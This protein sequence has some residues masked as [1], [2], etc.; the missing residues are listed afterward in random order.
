MRTQISKPK[1]VGTVSSVAADAVVGH[2]GADDD[3]QGSEDEEGD[4]ESDLLDGRLVMNGVG[5]LHHDILVRYRESVI[6]VG[7]C[8][9]WRLSM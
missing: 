5:S 1:S 4:G 9:I 2:E 6:H 3:A 8:G 7:H